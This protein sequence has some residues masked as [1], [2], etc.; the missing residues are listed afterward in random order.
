MRRASPCPAMP[1]PATVGR[2]LV[3]LPLAVMLAF[4]AQAG[5]WGREPGSAFLSFSLG[6]EDSDFGQRGYGQ[7]YGELGWARGLVSA[8]RLRLDGPVGE[9]GR[10]DA[11]ADV[12]LRW[13]PGWTDAVALGFEG[14]VRGETG[15]LLEDGTRVAAGFGLAAVHLGRGLQ[16][17]WGDGW[18]RLTLSVERPLGLT[19]SADQPPG[20]EVRSRREALV[21]MGLRTPGGWLGLASLSVFEEGGERT[22][23]L[24]PALGRQLG[25]GRDIVLELTVERGGAGTRGAAL[26]FWQAF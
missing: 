5:P 7:A 21:Q 13:H 12:L 1:A 2:W 20:Q 15:A 10:G 6:F 25:G 4:P 22:V 3:L 19:L 14:G 18:T 17:P 8:V 16:T 26:S 11:E 9:E 24:A 23:K